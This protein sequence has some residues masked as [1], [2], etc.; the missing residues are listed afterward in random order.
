MSITLS[1]QDKST[2]RTAAYG[3]VSLMAAAGAAGNPHKIATSGA[4]ALGSA[5]GL[6][7]HVTRQARVKAKGARARTRRRGQARAL[8]D[9]HTSL[10]GPGT[11]WARRA[12]AC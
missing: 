4:I 5:T 10:N 11:G 9:Q 1:D 12:R 3:A 7:G 8:L 2:L 6:V